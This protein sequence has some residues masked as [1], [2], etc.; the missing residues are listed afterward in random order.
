MYC[1]PT[2]DKEPNQDMHTKLAFSDSAN[3]M[4]PRDLLSF[5]Q[6]RRE[7]SDDLASGLLCL[8]QPRG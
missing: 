4:S 6:A 3:E 7:P 8:R 1:G 2:K 5:L